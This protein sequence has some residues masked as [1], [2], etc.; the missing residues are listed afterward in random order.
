M[1]KEEE[2]RE[3]GRGETARRRRVWLCFRMLLCEREEGEG[4]E[5]E[6]RGGGGGKC[7]C[8][9]V[10]ELGRGKANT[11]SRYILDSLSRHF[12]S[13]EPSESF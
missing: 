6:G 12:W 11:S 1:H 3:E 10:M 4:C 8:I 9:M 2:K 7:I 13:E 5:G